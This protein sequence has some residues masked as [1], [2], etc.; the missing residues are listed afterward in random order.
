M[1]SPSNRVRDESGTV[2]IFLIGMFLV[3]MATGAL[4]FDSA[5]VMAARR[6]STKL[7]SSAARLAAQYPDE[8]TFSDGSP[9]LSD[10]GRTAA[11]ELLNQEGLECDV[12]SHCDV[13]VNGARVTVVIRQRV[14]MSVLLGIAER[15]VSGTATAEIQRDL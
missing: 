10:D 13:T 11:F 4:V 8:T 9:T 14:Q 5:R 2:T 7:A 3:I 6:E 1:K 12:P 15:I